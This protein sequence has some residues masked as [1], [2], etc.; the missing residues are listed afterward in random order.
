MTDKIVVQ[1]TSNR[2]VRRKEVE[3]T[4][5]AKRVERREGCVTVS[6]REGKRLRQVNTTMLLFIPAG[7][8]L[9]LSKHSRYFVRDVA[10]DNS[11]CTFDLDSIY[12]KLDMHNSNMEIL[13]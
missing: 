8:K 11:S 6:H 10:S 7:K 1:D 5:N 9:E 3:T 4:G 13:F 12:S 2:V